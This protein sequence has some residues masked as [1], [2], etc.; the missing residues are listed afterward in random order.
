MHVLVGKAK[1]VTDLVDHDVRDQL[2]EADGRRLPL[3]DD[4]TA[5]KC[6]SFREHARLLDALPVERHAL[7]ETAELHWVPEPKPPRG[8]LISDFLDQEDDVVEAFCKR[9]R[10]PIERSPCD[11]F[12]VDRAWYSTG[13]TLRRGRADGLG[14]VVTPRN[15]AR[16]ALAP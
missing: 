14:A 8:V 2:L 5:V 6:D 1:M 4:R 13:K 11:R 10:E 12:D 7:V 3:G 16:R 15:L 9:R